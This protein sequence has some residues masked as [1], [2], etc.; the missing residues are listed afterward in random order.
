MTPNKS[1]AGKSRLAL[2]VARSPEGDRRIKYVTVDSSTRHIPIQRKAD[3]SFHFGARSSHHNRGRSLLDITKSHEISSDVSSC[4][5]SDLQ[6]VR[7]ARGL[8]RNPHESGGAL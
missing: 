1:Y 4:T 7:G 5:P 3:V 6:F 2:I 8:V